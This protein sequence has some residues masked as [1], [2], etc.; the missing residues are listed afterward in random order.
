MLVNLSLGLALLDYLIKFGFSNL[1]ENNV[2]LVSLII[3]GQVVLGIVA[4]ISGCFIIKNYLLKSKIKV[5]RVKAL[6]IYGQPLIC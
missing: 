2:I 1:M 3:S 4:V 5:F 6:S